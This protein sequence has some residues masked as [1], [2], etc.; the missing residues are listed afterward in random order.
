MNIR[1]SGYEYQLQSAVCILNKKIRHSPCICPQLSVPLL[2]LVLAHI[3]LIHP[4]LA[5][6]SSSFHEKL[7]YDKAKVSHELANYM[8]EMAREQR[9][10]VFVKFQPAFHEQAA[11]HDIGQSSAKKSRCARVAGY[12]REAFSRLSHLY[13]LLGNRQKEKRGENERYEGKSFWLTNDIA[14]SLTP[15]E[16][17]ELANDSSIEKIIKVRPVVLTIPEAAAMQGENPLASSLWNFHAIGMQDI[18]AQGLDGNGVR[19][20]HLDT[21]ISISAA[22]VASKVIDWAEFTRTGERIDSVPHETAVSAHGTYTASILVGDATGIAPGARLLSA[23]VLPEGRGTEEQVLAGLEWIVDPNGDGKLD[24]GARIINMS[25]GMPEFSEILAEAVQR[26]VSLEILPVGAVGNEGILTCY[27]PANMP[28]A[29]GVGAIDQFDK[30]IPQS[31]GATFHYGEATIVKPDI[32]APGLL[33]TGMDQNGGYQTLS[34]TSVATPHVTAAAALLLQQNPDLVLDDLKKFLL[35]SSRKAGSR[36]KDERYGM[37]ILDVSAATRFL[38]RYA[39]RRH[40]ADLVL[41][42]AGMTGVFGNKL[43]TYYSNGSSQ[44]LEE[45]RLDS[46]PFFGFGAVE[47][48]PIEMADVDGDGSADFLVRQK[49]MLDADTSMI[50]YLVYPATI[51]SGF[52]MIGQTWHSSMQPRG[53]E[54]EYL[55]MADIDGDGRADLLLGERRKGKINSQISIHAYLSNGRNLFE[56]TKAPWAELS[57]S[58][59]DELHIDFGDVDGD[60]REDLV[61]WQT[62]VGFYDYFPIYIFT[63]LSDG[64]RFRSAALGRSIYQYNNIESEY[65]ALRDVNGDG[66]ADLMMREFSQYGSDDRLYIHVYL[67]DLA[68]KFQAK[69][70]WGIFDWDENATIAGIADV[71]GDNAAD[72]IIRR[73]DQA[74]GNWVFTGAKSNGQDGFSEEM[75]PWLVVLDNPEGEP[76][77]VVGVSEVGLGDWFLH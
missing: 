41:K 54:P 4:G 37:G 60:G 72:L 23:L 40:A 53:A 22:D 77:E 64:A 8:E 42:D 9:I 55:G 3:V 52:S 57:A 12:R 48:A 17:A 75:E 68:G 56:E 73:F 33:V 51:G 32:T 7:H 46:F 38:D 21:G 20:G 47:S 74:S 66:A 26:I 10:R 31:S 11:T 28:E 43:S 49:T 62:R 16:I 5:A 25:F 45:E 14:V 19:I 65:L 30:V 76:P 15:E 18:P 69:Q 59:Y 70:I 50:S 67:S 63:C 58:V 29:V 27:F 6:S 44:F 39:P 71:N 13:S 34:G 35:C 2:V 1:F 36:E 24:D 61:Y